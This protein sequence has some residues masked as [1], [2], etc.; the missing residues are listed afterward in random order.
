MEYKRCPM[1]R[2][3]KATDAFGFNRGKPG[4][5]ATYCRLCAADK[6]RVRWAGLPSDHP[7]RIR[8]RTRHASRT[9]AAEARRQAYLRSKEFRRKQFWWRLYKKYGLTE[10]AFRE[11]FQRQRGACAI[12]RTVFK[13]KSQMHVDHCHRTGK[14]RE[15][16]CNKCNTT[17]GHVRED[18]NFLESLA[19]YL[20]RHR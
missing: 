1:C 6:A 3:S 19:E 2:L 9:P 17:L 16:L 8:N 14:V 10:V 15:I 11:M 7:A 4:G 18:L 20:R 5:R 13:R 12:C